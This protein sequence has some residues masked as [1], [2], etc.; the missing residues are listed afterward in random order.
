MQYAFKDGRPSQHELG[1][2]CDF[3]FAAIR[4]NRKEFY[5]LAKEIADNVIVPYDQIILESRGA[6]SVWIHISYN[7]ASSRRMKL[8]M[9]NDVVVS[10]GRGAIVLVS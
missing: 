6:D 2:A 1:Q 5:N 7:E 3:G 9:H 4:G 8:T 10:G